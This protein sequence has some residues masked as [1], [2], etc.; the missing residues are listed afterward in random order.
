[1]AIRHTFACRPPA[2]TVIL[3]DGSAGDAAYS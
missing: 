2:L 1:M 3:K